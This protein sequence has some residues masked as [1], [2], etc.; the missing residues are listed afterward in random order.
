MILIATGFREFCRGQGDLDGRPA[1]IIAFQ[2][3][4]TSNYEV[5]F[6]PCRICSLTLVLLN[7]VFIIMLLRIKKFSYKSHLKD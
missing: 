4:D 7:L 1:G 2:F 3:G 6:S 5:R